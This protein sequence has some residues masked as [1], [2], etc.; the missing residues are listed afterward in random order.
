[1]EKKNNKRILIIFTMILSIVLIVVG[2]VFAFKEKK[3]FF[4]FGAWSVIKLAP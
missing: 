3:I 2:F 1:M 4:I